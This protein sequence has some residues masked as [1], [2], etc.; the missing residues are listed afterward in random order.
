MRTGGHLE[1]GPTNHDGVKRR[2]A[3]VETFGSKD[4]DRVYKQ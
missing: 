1:I 4:Q 2:G 3:D